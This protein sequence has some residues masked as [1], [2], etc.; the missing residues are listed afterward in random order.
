[1]NRSSILQPID[2]AQDLAAVGL[3]LHGAPRT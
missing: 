2:I 3:D 1:M